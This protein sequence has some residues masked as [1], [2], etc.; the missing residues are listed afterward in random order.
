MPSAIC[1]RVVCSSSLNCL[2][3]L[4]DRLTF[5]LDCL[6][7]LLDC[8]ALP[9]DCLALRPDCLALLLDCLELIFE[10]I[11]FFDENPEHAGLLSHLL[12]HR[13]LHRVFALSASPSIASP[14]WAV[15]LR[16]A[17]PDCFFFASS[18]AA[19]VLT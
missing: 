10:S 4:L 13:R 3:F 18:D 5:L 11:D 14:P 9:P 2:T 17:L 19:R 1:C 12:L 7:L 15:A 8:L 16:A 6:A